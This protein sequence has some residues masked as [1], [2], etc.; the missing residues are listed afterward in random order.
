MVSK[1]SLDV[2]LFGAGCSRLNLKPCLL[3]VTLE[4]PVSPGLYPALSVLLTGSGLASA[5][6]LYM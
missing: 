3:Q 5:G 2:L 4:S 1:Q 6:A